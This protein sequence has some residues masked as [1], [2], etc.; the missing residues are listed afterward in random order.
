M[1]ALPIDMALPLVMVK[2]V[3]RAEVKWRGCIP[4]VWFAP[5]THR[6]RASVRLDAQVGWR[7]KV[8]VGFYLSF[9][10]PLSFAHLHRI[11]R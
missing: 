9:L 8:L 6:E 10:S 11:V 7:S 5:A 3:T 4:L 2:A 1:I